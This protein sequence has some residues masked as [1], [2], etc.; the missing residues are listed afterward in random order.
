MLHWDAWNQ[1]CL[2]KIIGVSVPYSQLT[3][4]AKWTYTVHNDRTYNKHRNPRIRKHVTTSGSGTKPFYKL[5]VKGFDVRRRDTIFNAV[6][7]IWSPS[8]AAPIGRKFVSRLWT[9]KIDPSRLASNSQLCLSSNSHTNLRALP[10]GDVTRTLSLRFV[11]DYYDIWVTPPSAR[12][13]LR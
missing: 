2:D 3:L 8:R 4:C 5:W 9:P 10:V 6:L 12:A 13:R 7:F 11:S 1:L